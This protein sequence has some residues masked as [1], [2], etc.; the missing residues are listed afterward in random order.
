MNKLFT[1]TLFFF[2]CS[3]L[4]LK[5]DNKDAGTCKIWQEYVDAQQSGKESLLL[6]FSYAG[7]HHGEKGIP[8]VNHK[9][10]NVCD[11]GAVPNDGKSDRSAFEAAIKAAEK[12]GSGVIF[13]PKGRYHLRPENAP[14]APIVISGSNIVLRGEGCGVDGTELF[15]EYP[16]PALDMKKLYSSPCLITFDGHK[17]EQTITTIVDDAARGSYEIVV[18][19]GANIKKGDWICVYLRNN[20]PEVIAQE[21]KPYTVD[22]KW[23]QILN[24]GV[25]IDDYH[26]VVKVQGNKI[27]LKEPLMHAIDKKWGFEVRTFSHIS[28]VG[29]E[30]LAFVGNW[31]GE[32]KHHRSWLD[33]GGYKPLHIRGVVNSWLRR[34]RFTDVSEGLSVMGSANVSVTECVITGNTGHSAMRAQA[35]SRVFFGLIEDQ[36][37]Q[38]HSVGFSKPSM[39]TVLW[40]IKTNANSCFESHATQ[41]RASLL[42]VCEGALKRGRAGGA[43][44]SNPN[45]LADLVFWNYKET[46]E[47]S[48]N[49]DFWADDTPFWRFLPPIIVGFHGAGTT[50]KSSQVRYEESNG[51]PV[52]PESLYEAQLKLRLGKLPQWIV[53]LK[54]KAA[55][56]HAAPAADVTE[57]HD[58]ASLQRTL[59]SAVP[60]KVILM[61]D[62]EY[63]DAKLTLSVSGTASQ[64]I[65]LKAKHPGKVYFTGDV[66]IEMSGDYN[67]IEGIYF[68]DGARN[69]KEWKTHGPGLVAIYADHCEVAECM[70]YDF[71]KAHSA[72]ITTSLDG[73]GRVPQYCHIHHCAFIGKTTFDQVINLNNTLKKTEVGEPG[74]PMYH[75]ISYCYFSNPP[76][77]GNAGG[78]IRIGYWR[79]DFG[80][81]LVDHN[82]F[83]RQDSEPEIVTSKSMEN[84]YY[85]N[86]ILNCQGTLNLRHGDHQVALNNIFLSTDNLHEY[87]GMYVW[88]SDHLIGNN[89]FSLPRT[90]SKRG[91]AAVFFNCGPKASEH[92]LAYHI[93]M[94]KNTFDNIN[95]YVFNFA[96]LYDRRLEVYG[97]S[98]EL[99]HD[100]TFIGNL[101]LSTLHPQALWSDQ[102]GNAALQVWKENRY[103]GYK[104]KCLKTMKG[105]SNS[106]K[107]YTGTD[108]SLK[109]LL[110]YTS[111][112]GIPLDFEQVLKTP[113]TP[114]PLKR[115][116]VGPGWCSKY[117]GDYFD[118]G[119]RPK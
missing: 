58:V 70:F 78:G 85:A 105:W 54:A 21:L 7:Y 77:K 13:F 60:G 6:N 56:S 89:Y 97:K 112:E 1:A 37:A 19:S 9:I 51:T 32:F 99:P 44:G 18:K 90:L 12:H 106:D 100:I 27:T 26:Q 84:V 103:K 98:M 68:K 45:H 96:P 61:A 75:R 35:S 71:D 29:V 76:K 42:D 114:N 50:F 31:K 38:W 64:R 67:T 108:Y 80:R 65:V 92:A 111:I 73:N 30:D 5:A 40:R 119:V 113:F 63:R 33:D 86:T 91:G 15:M 82:L 11:Y 47:G 14:N 28:E 53:E 16:N 109:E 49:F 39:G 88:G 43:V 101:A 34:C 81:C 74:K 25:M 66:K 118:T 116:D 93:V 94:V 107:P 46:D 17:K 59:A 3:S 69:P 10:F 22:P 110:G 4:S 52:Q 72:Y 2:C 41:P 83:E 117:P 36:P 79:K 115:H 87:G 62:G 20:S 55:G 48:E 95:G 8:E 24:E 57:V 104:D 102:N 23:K